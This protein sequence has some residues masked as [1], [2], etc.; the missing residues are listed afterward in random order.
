M[1][2]LVYI[3]VSLYVWEIF[4][5]KWYFNSSIFPKSFKDIPNWFKNTVVVW[6]KSKF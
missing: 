3:G 2:Y 1:E 4:F 5:R 6:V